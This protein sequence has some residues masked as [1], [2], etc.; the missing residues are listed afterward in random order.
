MHLDYI[1]DLKRVAEL[2]SMNKAAQYLNIST[3][4]LSKRI[5]SVENYFE[6]KL[7][8]RNAKGIF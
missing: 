7:F 6:C 2:Q 3:P 5:K 8:Y 1:E 4:A